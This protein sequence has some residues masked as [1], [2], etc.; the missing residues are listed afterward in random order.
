[1][2][3]RRVTSFQ[4]TSATDRQ[5]EALKELGF[6]SKTEII[7]T[8]IDRMYREETRTMSAANAANSNTYYISEAMLGDEATEDDARRMVEILE[9]KGYNVEYGDKLGQDEAAISTADWEDGLDIISL[10][11]YA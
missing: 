5:I 4:L 6:G 9:G 10:E 11:K 7:R 8:A 1:M 2:T 3:T